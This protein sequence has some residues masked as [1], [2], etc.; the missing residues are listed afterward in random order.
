MPNESPHHTPL[1]YEY[2][3]R[4]SAVLWLF[5]V[6]ALG[7]FL[8]GYDI[9]GTSF[10]VVQLASMRA[11]S[12]SL[13]DSP[14]KTGWIVSSPSAGALLG[15]AF[16]MYLESLRDVRDRD[17]TNRR[18]SKRRWP[19]PIGRRTEL[20]YSGIL[21]AVGGILQ[22]L[23]AFS[24]ETTKSLFS[25]FFLLSLGRWIYG[26][27]IG[28]AMHGGPT[29]LAE[30]MPPSVR[31]MVVGGKELAIVVGI[32]VGFVAGNALTR[33]DGDEDAGWARVYASTLLASI[34]V[35]GLSFTIPES[36]RYLVGR[37]QEEL[38]ANS[39]HESSATDP[40]RGETEQE[41][42]TRIVSTQ[43][44]ESLKFVWNPSAALSE[45][46]KLMAI[47]HRQ[48]Q[49]QQQRHDEEESPSLSLWD[50]YV[51]PALRAGLGL[52]ILQQVTGQPSVLSYATPIL[53][54]VPGL[55]G[56]ASVILAIFKLLAT[57]VSVVLVET[58]GRKTLLTVGCSLM[59]AALL[60]LTFA[61]SEQA[62]TGS[63]DDD[64]VPS[65][66]DARSI[67]TLLGMFAYIAG[68]QVGFG[69][70]AWLM[71]SEVFP[72]SVR[73]KAVAL[74]VLANFALNAI[75]QFLVPILRSTLGMSRTFFVFGALAAYSVYFVQTSVPE[76]KGLTLEEIEEGLAALAS[77]S[78]T[79]A[80]TDEEERTDE[81]TAHEERVQLLSTS[82]T[83]V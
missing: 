39:S 38:C 41:R 10:V 27:G 82:S 63:F 37:Q 36:A 47:F 54:R 77:K 58:R 43:V 24:P 68:Y 44:L 69:P 59:F 51:R 83:P 16:L 33:V 46:R 45:H 40:L 3:F 31:G 57:S 52:V 29:Y 26:A 75:V 35:I 8:F 73:G 7:G 74:A 72:Q 60:V 55:S 28:F 76:T 4:A 67:L 9:G 81:N 71:I 6:P 1:A 50:P 11:S 53:A 25:P 79:G 20:R 15:T 22:Y 17:A 14:I 65:E 80:K 13:K 49:Q 30:T 64:P 48:L 62:A 5:L 70:I 12:M 18:R 42:T 23:S 19:A 2:D 56:N 34:G 78:V 32:L 66:L 21:Y 61:F